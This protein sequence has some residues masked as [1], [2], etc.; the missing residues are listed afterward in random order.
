MK[1][2]GLDTQVRRNNSRSILLLLS[3]PLLI[4]AG[5]FGFFIWV[6]QGDM[7]AAGYDFITTIPF[8]IGGVAIWFLIAFS[9]HSAMIN[10][11]TGS[12]TLSRKENMR[13][14]NLT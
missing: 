2:V 5:V 9:G 6:H 12:E 4:F 3:F 14:Y 8:A 7:D 1:Y 10:L 11:S 13:V